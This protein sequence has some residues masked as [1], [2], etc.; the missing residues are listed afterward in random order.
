VT[1]PLVAL[2]GATGFVGRHIL[3]RLQRTGSRIRLLVRSPD[4]LPDLAENVQ[5]TVGSL[6]D[7]DALAQ[8]VAEASSVIHC[9]GAVRG[10]THAQFDRVNAVAAGDCAGL[11]QEAGAR[12]FL[13]ISSLAA[14]E[15]DLS[16]YAASKRRGEDAVA[17]NAGSMDVTVFRPPAVY[18]PGDREMLPLF[19]LMAR[20]IAPV[21]GS[22]D[23]RFSLI[24]V[25]DLADAVIA[26]D[27][28]P[29]MRP[30]S[31]EIDDGC[32][33]GYGWG[34]VCRA[35]ETITGRPV[36]QIGL[37]AALLG[38]PAAINTLAGLATAYSPMFSLG[39]LRELRH[40]D[41][42]CRQDQGPGIPGWQPGHRLVEGLLRTPG[43]RDEK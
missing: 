10:V 17:A 28:A 13:L 30:G 41:W 31:I 7:R 18:G 3:D 34:D 12:R 16:P 36:R 6:T 5:V 21:F 37:P 14:R 39:K 42:V 2:T 26:W 20:G 24:F 40:P 32:P 43:W 38:I 15:P 4:K 29:D 8:L 11:A 27:R 9:A 19:R 1:A 25:E 23:A 33:G 22:P 35:V